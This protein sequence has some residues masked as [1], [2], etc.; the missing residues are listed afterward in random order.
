MLTI[1]LRRRRRRRRQLAAVAREQEPLGWPTIGHF[2]LTGSRSVGRPAKQFR[3]ASW[4]ALRAL[5]FQSGD[6]NKLSRC[7][8]AEFALSASKQ[9]R[10]DMDNKTCSPFIRRRPSRSR[11]SSGRPVPSIK[12]AERCRR[13]RRRRRMQ[14]LGAGTRLA[15]GRPP[16]TAK[17]TML[18]ARPMLLSSNLHRRATSSSHMARVRKNSL[19]FSDD[20]HE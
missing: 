11:P 14:T 15:I 17:T 20:Q 6:R 16:T 7:S 5:G 19:C 9:A 8:A 18:A 12:P 2:H 13:R 1:S 10:D 3:L 4:I